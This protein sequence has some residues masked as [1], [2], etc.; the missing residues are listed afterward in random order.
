[1]DTAVLTVDPQRRLSVVLAGSAGSDRRLP[2]SFLH[3]GELL[4]E[5]VRRSLR[6]KVGIEGLDPQQLHVFDALDR[7]DRG[8]VLS[9]AHVDVVPFD[10]L[11]AATTVHLVP[12]TEARDLLYDHDEIVRRAVEWLRGEYLERPDPRRL[13]REPFTLRD[14]QRVHEAVAGRDLPRDTFRRGMQDKLRETG[15]MQTGVVGKPARL[16]ERKPAV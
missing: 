3:E 4:T 5:A 12:V 8:W 9:V 2:G 6:E 10:R 15:R 14:L 13:L 16:W 7:D 1:V 11:S